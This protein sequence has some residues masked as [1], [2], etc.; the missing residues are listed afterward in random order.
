LILLFVSEWCPSCASFKLIA[1]PVW[2]E[3]GDRLCVAIADTDDD[4]GLSDKFDVEYLPTMFFIKNEKRVE[5]HE[6]FIG[7]D[8]LV[9][10]INKHI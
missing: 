3:Y 4:G 8:L 9:E 2:E 6:N 1:D 7:K 10:L 5:T